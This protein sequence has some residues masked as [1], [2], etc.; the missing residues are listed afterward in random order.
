MRVAL[1]VRVS[2]TNGQDPE[3]QTRELCK[4]CERRGWQVVGEYVDTGISGA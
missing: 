2:T 3:L 1:Y 4:F